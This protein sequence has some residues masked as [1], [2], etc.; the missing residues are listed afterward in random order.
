MKSFRVQDDIHKMAFD[1]RNQIKKEQGIELTVES[2][3]D[4]VLRNGLPLFK[5]NK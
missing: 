4:N 1:K 5:I 3:I 2:I